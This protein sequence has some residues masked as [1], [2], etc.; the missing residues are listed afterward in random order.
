[1]HSRLLALASQIIAEA[2]R[3]DP[4]DAVLRRKLRAQPDWTS[5]EGAEVSR[6]VFAYYRWFAW[7]DRK[8]PIGQQVASSLELADKFQGHPAALTDAEL[9]ERAVPGWAKEEIEI[10][11]K[12]V[13]AIQS[14]PRLWLRARPGQGEALALKLG[15]CR[16]FREGLDI[17]EY[18]GREDLFRLPEF[19]R[20]EF[21]IQDISSQGVGL[22]CDPKPG[23]T[24]WDVC[25]GE[26]GK[27]LHLSDLMKNQGL[28]WAS[29][30]AA[31]RLARL[32]RR[33]ARAKIFNYRSRLWDGRAALPTK[34][35]FDGVL[36]DAPCTGVGTWQRN[37]HARWTTTVDD[38]R[39]LSEIQKALLE[40][41]TAVVKTGGRL[42]YAVC[43]LA[44]SETGA[45]RDAF[46]QRFPGFERLV[47]RHPL[48]DQ[49]PREEVWFWPQEHGGNG[50]FV[51]A[52]RR[53]RD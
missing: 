46:E 53:R 25:A 28:I 15:D 18:Q 19:H 39:D 35:R 48:N 33:A 43:S 4:A 23:E 20:G 9:L 6:A 34:T 7:C 26:G 40:R 11:G 49:P 38:V 24:W 50:M 44:R 32:K 45:V 41:A 2:A 37:P 13:R 36:V 17:L 5:Q 30:R 29:D 27:L 21:E 3:Q 10:S 31:W 52:W 42:V 14:E 1:M 22:L 8:Q 16:R 12:W 51:A 47:L